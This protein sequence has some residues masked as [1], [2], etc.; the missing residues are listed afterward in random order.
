MRRNEFNVKFFHSI[1]IF[2]SCVLAVHAQT[3]TNA[4]AENTNAID[5]I[6]SLVKTNPAPAAQP[7]RPPTRINSDS[8]DF[9]LANHQVIYRGHVHVDDPEMKLTSE[10]LVADLPQSGG[11]VNHIVAETNVVIDAIDEK[12]QAVHATGDKAVYVYGVENGATNETVTLTG[13]PQMENSQGTLTGDVIV[14]DRANNHLNATNQKM[15]F[16]QN[17][18]GA[19]A[20][21]N[22]PSSTNSENFIIPR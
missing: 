2:A 20:D 4:A 13:N 6:L 8:A 11:H 14:W 17:L 3:I 15:I 10:W 16:R 19:D 1:A 21:T 22:S 12:G 7:A 18:N 9:D 5:E